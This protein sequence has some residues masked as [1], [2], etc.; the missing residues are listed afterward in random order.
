MVLTW[1][2]RSITD[3][4]LKKKKK[5]K[6]KPVKLRQL[7]AYCC[8][9]H[10]TLLRLLI[11]CLCHNGWEQ[12]FK[13]R[14]AESTL[15]TS[16]KSMRPRSLKRVKNKPCSQNPCLSPLYFHVLSSTYR[17]LY[18]AKWE[19]PNWSFGVQTRSEGMRLLDRASA[20]VFSSC[21]LWPSLLI[22]QSRG[23]C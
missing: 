7:K 23:F 3:G 6:K 19:E 14:G 4:N 13:W 12:P 16:W 9:S 5:K 21:F 22:K 11:L 17:Q 10:E 2:N 20:P 15:V 1:G 8:L 18:H